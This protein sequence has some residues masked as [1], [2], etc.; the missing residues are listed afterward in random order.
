MEGVV[1]TSERVAGE[2]IR[3]WM[4]SL[5]SAA[6]SGHAGLEKRSPERHASGSP[7]LRTGKGLGD[8]AAHGIR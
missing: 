7:S 6:K 1:V 8:E 2:L 4:A 5:R 3:A